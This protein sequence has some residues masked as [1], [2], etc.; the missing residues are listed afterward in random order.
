MG[1]L[2]LGFSKNTPIWVAIQRQS[3]APLALLGRNSCAAVHY[4]RMSNDSSGSV[5]A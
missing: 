4:Q 2:D 1:S 3:L 5:A